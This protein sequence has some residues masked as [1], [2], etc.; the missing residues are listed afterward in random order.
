MSEGL[1]QLGAGTFDA[2]ILDHCLPD[3]TAIDCL[4][5]IKSIDPSLAVIV[6]T[7]HATIDLAIEAI[8]LGAEQFLVKPL[9]ALTALLTRAVELRRLRADA[10]LLLLRNAGLNDPFANERSPLIRLLAAEA[11]R[12]LASASPVLITGETGTGK[13]VL[14]R[15]LHRSGPR[16]GHAFVDL[17]CAGFSRELLESEFFGHQRG[18]FTGA[19]RDKPGLLEIGDGGTVFLDEIGDMEPIIQ[20]K[21]L[22][23]VEEKRFRRVGGVKELTV[24]VRLIAATNRDLRA[25]AT[26]GLFR[27][28]LYY[29]LSAIQLH[30]PTLRERREDLPLIAER[31]LSVIASEMALPRPVLEPAAHA[32]LFAHTWP[33]NLR[34]LRH[35]LERAV[36]VAESGRILPHHLR[37]NHGRTPG[38]A[39]DGE[40]VL[41]LEA[42]EARHI[43]SAITAT[44]GNLDAAATRLGISRSTLYQKIKKYQLS[45]PGRE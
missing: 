31:M 1:T 41:T 16:A 24:N 26:A 45:V 25:R 42:V 44:T 28:D 37:L 39:L 21:L 8:R 29:R 43:Q 4:A 18:A 7:G 10:D 15:W 22:K 33:G 14:A 2:V 38:A 27:E 34:E 36:L 35:V 40:S 13:G 30:M 3:G 19:T 5:R 17:N 11:K 23:V 9:D 12:T 32:E 20:G 6:L